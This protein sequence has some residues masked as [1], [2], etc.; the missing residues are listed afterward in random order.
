MGANILKSVACCRFLR[1][2]RMEMIQSERPVSRF[3]SFEALGVLI[4]TPTFDRC[5]S[6]A[7]ERRALAVCLR[8][9]SGPSLYTAAILHMA[10]DVVLGR[11]LESALPN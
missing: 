8:I 3:S 7:K 9:G 10:H 11:N 5:Q 4:M 2:R 1:E 6:I